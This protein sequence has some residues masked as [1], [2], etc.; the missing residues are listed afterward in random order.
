MGMEKDYRNYCNI[1]DVCHILA[2]KP[3]FVLLTNNPDKIKGL[4]SQVNQV[5]Q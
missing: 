5:N 3:S 1:K 2:V 4:R